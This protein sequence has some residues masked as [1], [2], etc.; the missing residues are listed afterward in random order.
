MNASDDAERER[1]ISG[2]IQR[3]G[4]RLE[5]WL[6]RHAPNAEDV[7]DLL[8]DAFCELFVAYRV[9][10]PIRHAGAWPAAP[11]E[12]FIAHEIDGRSFEEIAQ[13]TGESVNTLLSRKHSAVQS[14]RR[15][16][17]S[18]YDELSRS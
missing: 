13:V 10:S 5:S 2:V 3:E 4:P 6:R 14:L 17:R 18:S 12:V 7:E 15:R 11:R 9:T 16:L 8:Q 1:W